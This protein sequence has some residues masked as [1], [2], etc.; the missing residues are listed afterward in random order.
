MHGMICHVMCL[1]VGWNICAA[2]YRVSSEPKKGCRDCRMLT[3]ELVCGV[4]LQSVVHSPCSF[5]GI[6]H[7]SIIV[8][9]HMISAWPSAVV[10]QAAH[11]EVGRPEYN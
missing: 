5:L 11:A 4:W 2:G 8:S 6:R 3:T 1:A 7:S 10:L 9:L